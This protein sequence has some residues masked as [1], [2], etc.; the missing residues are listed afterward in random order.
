MTVTKY[1]VLFVDDDPNILK[2]IQRNLRDKFEICIAESVSDA[3][4]LLKEHQFPVIVSD[5]KMPEMN[6]ADF[7]ILAKEAQPEAIRILLTG[8]SGLEE[9][10]KAINESDIYKF[11]KKPCA[12]DKLISTIDTA[13]RMY[14]AHHIEALIMDKSV[15]GFVYIISDLMNVISPEIFKK[16]SD[17]SKIAK[18]SQTKFPIEDSWSVEVACLLM[19]LGSIHYKVYK[20]SDLYGKHL[21]VKVL[22]KS[23]QLIFNIPKFEEVHNILYDLALFY[24]KKTF[25]ENLDSDSKVLKLIIDYY[26]MVVT[27]G[28]KDK[29]LAMYS[30]DIIEKLP[31]MLGKKPNAI[32]SL[33]AKQL[34]AGMRAAENI[35]TVSGSIL[36]NKGEVLKEEDLNVLNL[37]SSKNV[38][39]EPFKVQRSSND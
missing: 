22:N 15:K 14:N 24:E 21:M 7:L 3:L 8:E 20:Y 32:V 37:F 1:D 33:E 25:I 39:V 26:H 11:L 23:A 31:A 6:G 35:I 29:F 13:L 18:S 9:A 16:S 36:V 19:Y 27:K 38:L 30:K 10:I 4:Q 2:A 28:F 34:S 12:T 5:M 17:V